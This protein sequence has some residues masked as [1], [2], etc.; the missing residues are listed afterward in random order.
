MPLTT[1]DHRDMHALGALP[2]LR[3]KPGAPAAP[4]VP[5]PPAVG[6]PLSVLLIDPSPLTRECLSLALAEHADEFSVVAASAP[7]QARATGPVDLVLLHAGREAKDAAALVRDLPTIT[8]ALPDASIVLLA[9]RHSP[10]DVL[11]ALRLG[12]R[13]CLS[14]DVSPDELCRVL[15]RISAGEVFVPADA[16]DAPSG[17]PQASPAATGPA[18]P[19]H[20][21]LTPRQSDVLVRIRQGKSNKVI[22]FELGMQESTVKVHVRNILKQLGATN[23]TEAVY[24]ANLG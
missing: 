13:G 7:E 8:A 18:D 20:P 22:A 5:A 9:N 14:H 6:R 1:T 24:L 2:P 16:V 19:A 10:G 15:R 4:A 12:V 11:S 3:S 17:E 21:A 23:R